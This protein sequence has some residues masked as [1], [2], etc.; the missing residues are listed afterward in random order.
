MPSAAKSDADSPASLIA[1]CMTELLRSQ[2]S[3]GLCSTQPGF[4]RIC[5]CSSWCLPRSLPEW[6]KIMNL[7]LVVPWSMAPTKS[8]M[9]TPLVCARWEGSGATDDSGLRVAALGSCAR[10]QLLVGGEVGA[11]AVLVEA[12]ADQATDERADDR[13]PPVHVAVLVSEGAAVA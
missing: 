3:T 8:A 12:A 7:E 13:D 1:V 2:I 6:S 9:V 10:L 11:D 5:S 4:G